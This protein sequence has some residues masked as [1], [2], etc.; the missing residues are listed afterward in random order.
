[1]PKNRVK[2]KNKILFALDD[3][4]LW[5]GRFIRKLTGLGYYYN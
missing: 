2:K 4:I 3:A 1:M 5:L